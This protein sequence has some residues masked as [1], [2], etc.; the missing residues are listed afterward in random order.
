MK[1]FVGLSLRLP[2]HVHEQLKASALERGKSL[3]SEIIER[4]CLG[5]G[6]AASSLEDRVAKLE[7]ALSHAAQ[8]ET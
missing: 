1:E 7:L 6:I 5:L 3:N 2:K 8:S 4:A